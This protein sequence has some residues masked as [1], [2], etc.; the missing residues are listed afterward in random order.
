MKAMFTTPEGITALCMLAGLLTTIA[1]N[2]FTALGWKRAA[3]RATLAGKVTT[4]VIKGVE[5]AKGKLDATGRTALIEVLREENLAADIEALVKPMIEDVR[6]GGT[7]EVVVAR[8]TA[9][10]DPRRVS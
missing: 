2:V 8:A 3:Q 5:R 9:R 4:T 1:A 10:L 6:A 7:T